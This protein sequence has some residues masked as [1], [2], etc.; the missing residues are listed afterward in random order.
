MIYKGIL[1]FLAL[2]SLLIS[3]TL[4]SDS[5][6]AINGYEKIPL[7]GDQPLQP[8]LSIPEEPPE[9][10]LSPYEQNKDLIAAFVTQSIHPEC[11]DEHA[12]FPITTQEAARCLGLDTEIGYEQF[13]AEHGQLQTLMESKRFSSVFD[14]NYHV[15]RNYIKAQGKGSDSYTFNSDTNDRLYR[16]QALMF[17]PWEIGNLTKITTIHIFNCNLRALPSSMSRLKNL[18]E[19]QLGGTDIHKFPLVVLSLKKLG[20]LVF[21]TV[22]IST[23]P[24]DIA[25]LNKMTRLRLSRTRVKDLPAEMLQMS[26]MAQLELCN[27][28]ME[29]I[30]PVIYH[31]TNLTLL[32]MSGNNISQVDPALSN[33]RMLTSLNLNDNKLTELP[34]ELTELKELTWLSLN[35]NMLTELPKGMKNL[36]RLTSLSLQNNKFTVFPEE[37]CEL[38]ELKYLYMNHNQITWLPNQI[39]L[40]VNLVQ[41]WMKDCQ[42]KNIPKEIGL[43]KKLEHLD[44]SRNKL[45][46]L[47]V[48]LTKLRWWVVYKTNGNYLEYDTSVSILKDH[49]GIKLDPAFNDWFKTEHWLR[50]NRNIRIKGDECVVQ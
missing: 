15:E 6:T 19:F 29:T 4:A 36:T 27:N 20:S 21:E 47:P 1:G 16:P 18:W 28:G 26:Q 9:P 46:T 31:L 39:G 45:E 17:F 40:L 2:S 7:L 48:E 23:I 43:L 50:E 24:S 10:Q 25:S 32:D 35:N 49:P 42:L 33:L 41:L 13:V 30:S 37:V 14:K 34:P 22:P 11:R 38:R 3:S 44:L 5:Y 12:S 8:V